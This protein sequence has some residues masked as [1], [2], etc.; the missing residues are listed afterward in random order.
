MP[1]QDRFRIDGCGWNEMEGG[2]NLPVG[3]ILMKNDLSDPRIAKPRARTKFQPL[4]L[5]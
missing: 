5:S 3:R 4:S 1:A 2:L